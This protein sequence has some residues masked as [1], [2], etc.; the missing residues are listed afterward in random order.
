MILRNNFISNQ[1]YWKRMLK[2][3]P[4]PLSQKMKKSRKLLLQKLKIINIMVE[5]TFQI[6]K[7]R[8]LLIWTWICRSP[9]DRSITML[10]SNCKLLNC[11]SLIKI[12]VKLS[13]HK[14][15]RLI[16]NISSKAMGRIHLVE[17]SNNSSTNRWGATWECQETCFKIHNKWALSSHNKISSKTLNSNS[18]RKLSTSNSHSHHNSNNSCPSSSR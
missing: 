11:K 7:D 4:K 17:H 10:Y 6:C 16:T 13:L 15:A 5:S 14:L 1:K 2:R 3:K 18:S 8:S 9:Q 12:L